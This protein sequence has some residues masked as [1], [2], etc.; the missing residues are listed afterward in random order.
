MYGQ[1]FDQVIVFDG[2]LDFLSIPSGQTFIPLLLVK[3]V[4]VGSFASYCSTSEYMR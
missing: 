3:V 2:V 1:V 4:A